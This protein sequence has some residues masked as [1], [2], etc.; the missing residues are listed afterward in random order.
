MKIQLHSFDLTTF[1]EQMKVT[2]GTFKENMHL[3]TLSLKNMPTLRQKF[4]NGT[5]ICSE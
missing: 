5:V 2:R 4:F 1:Y 3:M